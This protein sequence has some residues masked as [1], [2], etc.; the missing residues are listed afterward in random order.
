MAAEGEYTLRVVTGSILSDDFTSSFQNSQTG[1]TS[2]I[3]NT[4]SSFQ[5]YQRGF[6]RRTE[7][8]RKY[9]EHCN[10][11]VS[12]ST[13]RRH[14]LEIHRCMKQIV[15]DW[16]VE[17]VNSDVNDSWDPFQLQNPSLESNAVIDSLTYD[18]SNYDVRQNYVLGNKSNVND[19]CD[20]DHD[21]DKGVVDEDEDFCGIDELVVVRMMIRTTSNKGAM[22]P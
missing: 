17:E 15:T 22:S 12:R 6:K 13:Y 16:E 21:N 9:C 3:E 1:S 14:Q 7:H 8:K 18:Q 5:N 4:S 10:G 19:D 20:I 2:D 11:Y